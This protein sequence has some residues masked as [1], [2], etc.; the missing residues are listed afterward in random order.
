MS[1]ISVIIPAYNA[2]KT[3]PNVLAACLAQTLPPREVIVVDDGSTDHTAAV[4][5]GCPVV[6]VRQENQ[7]PAAAR[8]AGARIATSAILVFTDADCTPRPDWLERLSAALDEGADAA[9]GTYGIGNPGARLARLVHEE[10]V[11]RHARFGREV[12]FLGSFNMAVRRDTFNAAGG[13]DPAFREASAEDND[14]SY[15]MSDLGARMVFVRDATVDHI[16]PEQLWPYLRTQRRHG[17]WRVALYLKHR[18]RTRGDRYASMT[19]LAAVPAALAC[20]GALPFTIA[21]WAVFGAAWPLVVNLAGAAGMLFLR[22]PMTRAMA[23][24]A[25]ARD[26]WC[27]PALACIRDLAR[28]LGMIQGVHRFLLTAGGRA[29]WRGSS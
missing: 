14:L 15:R 5:E 8:N 23:R 20:C 10:I 27:Y 16:H 28:G 19:E 25:R 1:D 17:V 22:V 11:F 2:A 9:G 26:M 6:Y 7:G 18:G 24:H 13:F 4:A 3:L 29:M 21:C 12:D